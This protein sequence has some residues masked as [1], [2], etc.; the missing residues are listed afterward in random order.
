MYWSISIFGSKILRAFD[1]GFVKLFYSLFT[2]DIKLRLADLEILNIRYG[3]R[4]GSMAE[5]F[6]CLSECNKESPSGFQTVDK[7]T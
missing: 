7:K 5:I 2:A 6:S 1:S 4:R 3:S